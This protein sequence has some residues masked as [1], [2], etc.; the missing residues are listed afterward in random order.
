MKKSIVIN[1]KNAT[2]EITKSFEKKASIYGTVEYNQLNEVRKDYPGFRINVIAPKSSN[3]FQGMDYE[4]MREYI[5]SHDNAEANLVSLNTLI[6]KKLAYG[7][8]KQWF[9][10]TYPVF[11]ECKTRAAWILAA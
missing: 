4:F 9:V 10:D 8:I 1:H 6:E 3:V 11:K 5:K 7:E 2:I